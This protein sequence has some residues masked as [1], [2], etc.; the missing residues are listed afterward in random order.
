MALLDEAMNAGSRYQGVE[1]NPE[2][3]YDNP[4]AYPEA[5]FSEPPRPK[6]GPKSGDPGSDLLSSFLSPE[7]QG[8]PMITNLRQLAMVAAA[9]KEVPESI[10]SNVLRRMMG[11]RSPEQE[12]L[13]RALAVAQ[14][15]QKLRA[16]FQQQQEARRTQSMTNTQQ[17]RNLQTKLREAGLQLQGDR[18]MQN[19]YQ[20]AAALAGHLGTLSKQLMDPMMATNPALAADLGKKFHQLSQLYNNISSGLLPDEGED[21]EDTNQ[22]AGP[23]EDF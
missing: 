13:G 7:S 4:T 16:P 3:S 2:L 12:Q 1:S 10:R 15:Q 21:E 14:Y 6:T 9:L 23:G 19:R 18:V 17:Y 20:V 22:L 5:S 8:S 11:M